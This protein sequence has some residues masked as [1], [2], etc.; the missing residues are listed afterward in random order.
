MEVKKDALAQ[1][2]T[3]ATAT[4][5]TKEEKKNLMNNNKEQSSKTTNTQLPTYNSQHTTTHNM[6]GKNKAQESTNNVKSNFK[7]YI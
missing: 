1:I 3:A 2:E 5:Q 7:V 6:L 4:M